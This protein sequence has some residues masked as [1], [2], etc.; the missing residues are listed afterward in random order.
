MSKLQHM[1]AGF[2]D[3]VA[4]AKEKLRWPQSGGPSREDV[5]SRTSAA[6]SAAEKG[7]R[8][9]NVPGRDAR[10]VKRAPELASEVPRS[11]VPRL[12]PQ[13]RGAPASSNSS[14]MSKPRYSGLD[15]CYRGRLAR[16]APSAEQA[17]VSTSAASA[18]S[19]LDVSLEGY[20][21][22]PAEVQEAAGKPEQTM[23]AGLDTLS[24]PC[25]VNSAM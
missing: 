22:R 1:A 24:G 16:M 13:G 12:L 2:G 8:R 9:Q 3:H 11:K 7:A 6:S 14:E 17:A 5:A 21:V 15:E 10:G 25:F 4:A 20:N 23:G 18:A 19:S